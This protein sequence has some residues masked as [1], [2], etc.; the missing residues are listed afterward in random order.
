MFFDK[1]NHATVD[2]PVFEMAPTLK[3]MAKTRKVLKMQRVFVTPRTEVLGD[4]EHKDCIPNLDTVKQ[5][6]VPPKYQEEGI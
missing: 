4:S 5:A 1:D 6:G 3:Y 2:D